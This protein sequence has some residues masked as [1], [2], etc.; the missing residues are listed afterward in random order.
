M[1]LVCVV[2]P[3]SASVASDPK[4]EEAASSSFFF[5]NPFEFSHFRF[6]GSVDAA[7]TTLWLIDWSRS[8]CSRVC[9]SSEQ[10]RLSDASW[11]N[12]ARSSVDSGPTPLAEKCFLGT[13][14]ECRRF[15]WIYWGFPGRCQTIKWGVFFFFF[16]ILLQCCCCQ[17]LFSGIHCWCKP[18]NCLWHFNQERKKEQMRRRR[19]CWHVRGMGMRECEVD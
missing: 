2:T 3:V 8:V 5:L 16:L 19:S 9:S 18:T 15:C 14:V 4:E 7:V 6:W 17:R 12:Q 10:L 13:W 11:N 1:E